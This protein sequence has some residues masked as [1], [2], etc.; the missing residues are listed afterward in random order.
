[1]KVLYHYTCKRWLTSIMNDGFLRLTESNLL[2]MRKPENTTHLEAYNK[3]DRS[4][5]AYLYKPVVWLTDKEEPDEYGLGL[6]STVDKTEIKITV[7]KMPY[8]KKWKEWSKANGINK[9]WAQ[10]LSRGRD[11]NSWWVSPVRVRLEEI[12]KIENRYTGEV[13]YENA[14][15]I[16]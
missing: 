16:R 14:T 12:V 4:A 6:H 7:K 10:A 3:G 8:F 2:D 5:D 1:M 11:T 15:L 13:Y 9:E